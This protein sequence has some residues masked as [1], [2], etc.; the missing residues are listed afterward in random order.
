MGYKF[1]GFVMIG[2]VGVRIRQKEKDDEQKE[3]IDYIKIDRIQK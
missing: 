2:I 1:Q 3:K